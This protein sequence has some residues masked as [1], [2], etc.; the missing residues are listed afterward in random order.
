M[1]NEGSA[2][3][4]AFVSQVKLK[5]GMHFTWFFHRLCKFMKIFPQLNFIR[6]HPLNAYLRCLMAFLLFENYAEMCV[7]ECMMCPMDVKCAMLK[8]T[9][10]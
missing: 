8:F 5:F 4:L 7:S 1:R 3:C 6:P 9:L 10:K 2:L